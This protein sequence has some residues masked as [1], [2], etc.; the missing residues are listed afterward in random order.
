MTAV[1]HRK[2]APALLAPTR[3][4]AA[5]RAGA[6]PPRGAIF[7]ILCGAARAA[8]ASLC[9]PP[10]N[11]EARSARSAGARALSVPAETSGEIAPGVGS[12]S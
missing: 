1:A 9:S 12:E 8:R 10:L 7:A 4:P 11:R 3:P 5:G 2:T 6:R